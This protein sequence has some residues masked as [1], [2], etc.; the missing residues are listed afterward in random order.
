MSK[1]TY[2]ADLLKTMALFE[3][4]TKTRLKDCFT[5]KNGLLTFVVN[6]VQVGKAIG[7]QASNVKKFERL[8][9]RK[10]KILGFSQNL[11]KFIKNLVYPLKVDVEVNGNTAILK[12]R[13]AKTKAFLIGR[14]S[15]NLKNN[16][17]I[18]QKYFKNIELKVG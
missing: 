7:K 11:E 2:N 5:D 8:L 9:K 16:N 12:A 4:I 3:K 13:D 15:S 14:N 1:I 10:I 18:V 17:E 6:E